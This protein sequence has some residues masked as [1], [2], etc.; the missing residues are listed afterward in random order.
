LG[1]QRKYFEAH[2]NA[3]PA[4]SDVERLSHKCLSLQFLVDFYA[5]V[6]KPLDPKMT[7]KQVVD[8]LFTPYMKARGGDCLIDVV[9]CDVNAPQLSAFVRH[10]IDNQFTL[11]VESLTEYYKDAKKWSEVS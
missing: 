7:T 4:L 11:L 8:E 1:T 3:S 10:A 6:I 2:Y 5:A 9:K